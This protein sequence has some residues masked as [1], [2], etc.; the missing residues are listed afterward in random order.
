MKWTDCECV[1]AGWCERHQCLKTG[2]LFNLCQ[3]SQVYFERWEQGKGP[4][5][6]VKQ[7][8]GEGPSLIQ[9]AVNFGTAVVRHT[10]NGLQQ[11][12]QSTY[13]TRIVTCQKCPSCDTDRM[14]CREPGCGCLLTLKARWAS[15][16]CPLN[17]WPTVPISDSAAT[18]IAES[19]VTV[20]R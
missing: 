1:S 2:T 8:T 10:A 3:N 13:E 12:D 19:K 9:R 20:A 5:F 15:E 6:P 11:V 16:T 18:S 4:C 7:T 17:Y 14:V